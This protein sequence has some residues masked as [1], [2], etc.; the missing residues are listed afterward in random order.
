MSYIAGQLLDAG[1][2][3]VLEDCMGNLCTQAKE[4]A[5]EDCRVA[6]THA[7]DSAPYPGIISPAWSAILQYEAELYAVIKSHCKGILQLLMSSSSVRGSMPNL[8]SQHDE[9]RSAHLSIIS[10]L[11]KLIMHLAGKEISSHDIKKLTCNAE[12]EAIELHAATMPTK[13]GSPDAASSAPNIGLPLRVEANGVTDQASTNIARPLVTPKSSPKADKFVPAFSVVTQPC[14]TDSTN[15]YLG[16]DEDDPGL[17]GKMIDGVSN[18]THLIIASFIRTNDKIR[19][20]LL[21]NFTYFPELMFSNING[22]KI[23]QVSTGK[24]L[25]VLTSAKDANMPTTGIKVRDNFFIQNRFS[26]VPGMLN[27]PKNPLQKVNADGCFHFDENRQFNGPDRITGIM[28]VS[29]PGN[30]KEA[31][32]N[33]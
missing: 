10:G 20:Q 8:S 17:Y 28:S 16:D 18:G 7:A 26:L 30:V 4:H 12:G 24:P 9:L 32:N 27:K 13:R 29:A 33:C 31:M 5:L 2:E 15:A 21:K 1:G 3:V 6:S 23:H 22:L 19:D 14:P 11:A 25:P